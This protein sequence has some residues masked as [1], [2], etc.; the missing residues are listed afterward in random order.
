M[1]VPIRKGGKYT[2]IKADPFMTQS[3]FDELQ[4]KLARLKKE[5]QPKL[6]QEVKRLALMGDF[7]ENTAYQIAKGKLRGTNSKIDELS[8]N[9]ADAQIIKADKDNSTVQIGHEVTIRSNNK[10]IR[11]RILGSSESAPAQGTISHQSPLGKALLDERVGNIVEIKLDDK[12]V[13]YKIISII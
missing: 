10:D 3:K 11:Y 9:I 6:I 2:F 13:S 4:K 8:K 7:S 5:V 1:R 12:L